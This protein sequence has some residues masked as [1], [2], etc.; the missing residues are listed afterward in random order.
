METATKPYQARLR[1]LPGLRAA[2]EDAALTVRELGALSG[3]HFVSISE[4]ER[5]RGARPS[6]VRKLCNALGVR[7]IDLYTAPEEPDEG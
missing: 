1:R 5:G 7:P 4:I 3:V 6:T 2:R